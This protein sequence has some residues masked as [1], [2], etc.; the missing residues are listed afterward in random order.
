MME[1]A[2]KGEI[3]M[4]G[5]IV[6]EDNPTWSCKKCGHRWGRLGLDREPELVPPSEETAEELDD[7]LI[8]FYPGDSESTEDS[9]DDSE[10]EPT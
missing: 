4:G 8:S 5:C 2:E 1:A 7:Y 3:V 10:N 6:H 9:P